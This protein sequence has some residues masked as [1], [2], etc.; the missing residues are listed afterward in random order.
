M[1]PRHRPPTVLRALC[2][3][4]GL[5]A[6]AFAVA[7]MLSDRAPGLLSDLFGEDVRR[8]WGRIDASQR[9]RVL[10]DAELP[11]TDFV[12]HVIVWAV[13]VTLAATS[14]WTWAGLILAAVG[15]FTGSV[16]LELAQGR[17]SDTRSVE[18]DDV[19]ANA[20]GVAIGAGVAAL[21]YLA[22]SALAWILGVPDRR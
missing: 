4:L 8:L 11:E 17:F 5:G 22:W 21:M 6:I 7:L 14:I 16:A 18:L 15:G 2:A 20:T 1:S 19:V 13:V 12:I 3:L 9:T 10:D